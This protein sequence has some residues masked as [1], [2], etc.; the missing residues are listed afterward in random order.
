MSEHGGKR[1]GSGRPE[2]S[3]NKKTLERKVALDAFKDRVVKNANKLFNAQ[4]GLAVG[5]QYLFRID[6]VEKT[7]AQGKTYKTKEHVLVTDPDEIKEALDNELVNGEDYYYITTKTPDNKAIDSMFD[8]TFGKAKET[9]ELE[10]N[11]PIT[12]VLIQYVD[13]NGSVKNPSD[14][15]P[16]ENDA[17]VEEAGDKNSM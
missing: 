10:N 9:L 17:G 16:Q 12:Q 6:E 1:E 2:G 13:K 3:L 4:L 11:N 15:R 14:E 8:R 5:V 7:N